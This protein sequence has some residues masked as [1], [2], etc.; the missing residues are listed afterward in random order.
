MG[1]GR[2]QSDTHVLIATVVLHIQYMYCIQVHVHVEMGY[3]KYLIPNPKF[4]MW[5]FV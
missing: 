1:R 4:A 3:K 5:K 2:W